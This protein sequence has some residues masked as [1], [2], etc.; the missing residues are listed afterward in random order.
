MTP[1]LL[2]LAY[3]IEFLVAMMA[4]FTAWSEIGGQDALDL[5]P[6]GW[7]LGF[8]LS[9]CAAI[10]A[11]TSAIVANNSFWTLRSA[12]WMTAIVV[13]A[14]GMAA[15]TYYYALQVGANETDEPSNLSFLHASARSV[16]L[17]S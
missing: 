3:A 11:Y 14:G 13:V 9:L 5:M 16:A 8:S 7:K 4:T 17:F 6:W 10:V 2:R 15:V 1:K 12:R